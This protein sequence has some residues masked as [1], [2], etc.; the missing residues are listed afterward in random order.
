MTGDDECRARLEEL[1]REDDVEAEIIAR[2]DDRR[3]QRAKVIAERNQAKDEEGSE[4]RTAPQPASVSSNGQQERQVEANNAKRKPD[5]TEEPG[6]TRSKKQWMACLSGR[7]K[8]KESEKSVLEQLIA[9]ED[10]SIRAP[11]THEVVEGIIDN[12]NQ[13]CTRKVMEELSKTEASQSG[14]SVDITK[15]NS[16]LPMAKM[17]A[18]LGFQSGFVL[19]LTT[20]DENGKKWDFSDLKTQN[21]IEVRLREEF[22]W[23]LA[24]SLPST[25]FATTPS[26]N[27]T[28]QNDKLM[29]R[30]KVTAHINFT[31]KLCVMQSKSGRK[32]MIEQPVGTRAWRTQ[33]MNKLL[34][35]KAVGKVN[36][37]FDMYEMNAK[38]DWRGRGRASSATRRRCSRSWRST[39][40]VE[41]TNTSRRGS[42]K[43]PHATCTTTSSAKP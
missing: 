42:G 6:E 10:K 22:P 17:A 9:E 12:L 43:P 23:L 8:T 4:P 13:V 31:V 7:A 15:A 25:V 5:D 16:S 24:L 27:S 26:L 38:S 29:E 40:Q 32:F 18:S 21:E 34:F 41:D 11:S 14:C 37:D 19:D 33:L 20:E 39:R 3:E 35:E 1:M 36:F 30:R 28:R 2:R